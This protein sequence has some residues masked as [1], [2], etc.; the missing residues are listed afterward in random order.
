[1]EKY[2]EAAIKE[3]DKAYD[4][5]EV[6]VGAVIF[7][8]D[9]FLVKARNNKQKENNVIGHAEINCLKKA[10]SKRKS[11]I[12]DDC[13]ILITLEPCLFCL[14]A[15]EEARI[16]NVYYINSNAKSGGI[17]EYQKIRNKLKIYKLDTNIEYENKLKNFFKNK[18][19]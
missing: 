19:G 13:S 2:I 12:L 1:M 3:A 5:N 8:D 9:D 11:W 14:I 18:R 15:I 10:A 4:E 17:S 7:N 16:R 6:P